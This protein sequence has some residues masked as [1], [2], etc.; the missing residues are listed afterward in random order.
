[1]SRIGRVTSDRLRTRSSKEVPLVR[2]LPA[3]R[4]GTTQR[5]RRTMSRKSEPDA[6]RPAFS[7]EQ[8]HTVAQRMRK[9]HYRR[10]RRRALKD[11][12]SAVLAIL[13]L[14]MILVR[15][16]VVHTAYSEVPFPIPGTSSQ[17]YWL[18]VGVLT[19]S[20]PMMAHSAVDAWRDRIPDDGRYVKPAVEVLTDYAESCSEDRSARTHL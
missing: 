3:V 2:P 14:V 8:I 18:T 5:T 4:S 11:G 7:T 19:L 17:F 12:S 16:D 6:S 9:E 13:S 15:P 10:H 1:M 20:V